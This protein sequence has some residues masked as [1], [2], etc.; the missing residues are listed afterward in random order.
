MDKLRLVFIETK[1]GASS[2][3]PVGYAQVLAGQIALG[4]SFLID[5]PSRAVNV[6][7]SVS[8]PTNDIPTIDTAHFTTAGYDTYGQRQA[9]QLLP[10]VNE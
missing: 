2:A 9:V 4:S 8:I 3:N 5:N 6:K 1:S 7:G 10:Y